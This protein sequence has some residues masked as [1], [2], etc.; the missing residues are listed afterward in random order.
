VSVAQSLA[1]LPDVTTATTEHALRFYELGRKYYGQRRWSAAVREF[2]QAIHEQSALAEAYL[3]RGKAYLMLHNNA[4]AMNDFRIAEQQIGSDKK[5]AVTVLINAANLQQRKSF[6]EEQKFSCK[7]G[8]SIY[9]SKNDNVYDPL[10]PYSGN[11]PKSSK[12]YISDKDCDD[13]DMVFFGSLLCAAGIDQ[14]CDTVALAR[15]RDTGRW[16]RSKRRIGE[17]DSSEHASFSTEQGLGVYIYMV[18][19]GEKDAFRAWL[20]WI[21]KNPRIYAPLPSYCTHKECVFKP[22]DC[23]LF[24][25]VASHFDLAL[26]AASVCSP[27]R[28][29]DIP[30][31]EQIEKQFGDAIDGLADLASKYEQALN[32]LVAKL[33]QAFGFPDADKLLPTPIS[34]L[35]EQAKAAS[36]A[37]REAREKILGPQIGEAAA[38]LAQSLTL[39]NAVVNGV[40]IKDASL[41]IDTGKLVYRSDNVS[42]EG[43]SVTTTGQV[44]YNPNGEHIAAVE[45]FMLRNLGYQSD[46]L[47]KAAA[48]IFERDKDNPFF[49][50]LAHG[51]SD[52]MLQLILDKC[53]SMERTSVRRFQWFPERGEELQGDTN[54][55]A[56][57]ESMYWDCLFLSALYERDINSAL[58]NRKAGDDPL[59]IL[60][61]VFRDAMKL[62]SDIKERIGQVDAKIKEIDKKLKDAIPGV[63]DYCEHNWCPPAVPPVDPPGDYCAHNWCP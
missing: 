60:G 28:A 37:F 49:E 61:N 13:G 56:W 40:D 21:D 10:R 9:A 41:K 42:I 26:R 59:S 33:G 1:Q 35:R 62:L 54:K 27:L 7:V 53:P 58:A 46:E 24:V 44:V 20:E 34:D 15:A 8:D 16:W 19:T 18:K 50:Y 12:D 39:I 11:V 31:P 17:P 14:G 6:W 51:R 22:I 55:P 25:T 2:D 45:V 43:A 47:N 38:R 32:G 3:A 23:P 29:L 57:A 5:Q 30:G 52:R 4:H 48:I 36:K 63:G